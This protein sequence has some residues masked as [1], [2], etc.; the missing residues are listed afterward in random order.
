MRRVE[1]I[2]KGDVQRVG[3]RDAVQNIARKLRLSGTVENVEPYDV[4]IVAEGE[5]A[6]LKEFVNAVNIQERPI[7]VEELQ[8]RWADATGEFQYF[9][10]LRG[11]WQ[12][13]LGE[14]FDVAIRY[15]Q[16]SIELGEQNLAVGRENLSIGRMMLE[17]QDQMLEKQDQMLEKQDQMLEKQDQMLEKQDAMLEKQDETIEELRGV[18][19]DLREHM[20]KR[21]ARIENEIAEIKRAIREL[22]GSCI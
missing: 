12:E 22:G 13:E 20:D 7:R 17:K 3:Y 10:I 4:R 2:A 6:A 9:R 14:R 1:I 18:R 21:F 5:E 11:D 16:R 19:S 15:L 8:V